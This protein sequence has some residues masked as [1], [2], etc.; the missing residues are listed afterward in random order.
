MTH[1]RR[2][3]SPRIVPPPRYGLRAFVV[4]SLLVLVGAAVGVAFF[5]GVQYGREAS[6][7]LIEQIDSIEQERDVL[8]ARVAELKQQNIVLERSQQIDREASK[9]ASKQLKDAQDERLAAEKEVSFLR[10][11]IQEGGGGILQPRDFKLEKSDEPGEFGYSFTIRQLI[12]EF[13]ESTGRVDLKI[14]GTRDGKDVSLSVDKLKG[15]EPTSHKM[16]FKHF[17]SFAGRIRVPDD[18]D[19]ESLV[20]EI[21]PSTSKLI[22]VS[23]T[24]PW[25]TE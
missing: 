17:Q 12:P 7:P 14:L 24:F 19:P 15:S 3:V 11:L 22:P 23:E 8:S 2:V 25:R 1:G 5:A 6:V 13:G 10:R 18:F 16:E 21:K 4:L 20:V 9:T